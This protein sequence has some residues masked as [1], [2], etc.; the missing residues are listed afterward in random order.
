MHV[1]TAHDVRRDSGVLGYLLSVLVA[2]AGEG[3]GGRIPT[4]LEYG[5]L[6]SC[7]S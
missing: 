6:F 5:V 4:C 2:V 7:N 3:P 1:D